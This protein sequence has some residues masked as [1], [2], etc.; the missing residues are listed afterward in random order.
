MSTALPSARSYS[1]E[2]YVQPVFDSYGNCS[3]RSR[4]R[5]RSSI[6]STPSSCARQSTTRSTRYTASAIR[7]EHEYATPPG[8]LF[9]NAPV[10]RQG[11]D[12]RCDEPV[13]TLK[14]PAGYVL[15]WAVALNAPW[16]ATTST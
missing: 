4:L 10:T 12:S 7:N 1:P 3:A 8:A 15:G 6:G 14:K 2:S 11:E 16:S 5:R 13:K 9:V